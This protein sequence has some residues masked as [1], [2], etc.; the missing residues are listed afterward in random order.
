MDNQKRWKR[1][2]K[3]INYCMDK[4]YFII[5]EDSKGG[6]VKAIKVG[7]WE[8]DHTLATIPLKPKRYTGPKLFQI[9]YNIVGQD[10]GR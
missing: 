7:F 3:A 2:C 6:N 1:Y 9:I 5:P 10:K 4:G 8:S